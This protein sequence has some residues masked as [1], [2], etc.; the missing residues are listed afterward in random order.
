MIVALIAH[1]QMNDATKAKANELLRGHP[2]FKAHFERKMPRYLSGSDDQRKAKWYFAHAGTWPDLVRSASETVDREDVNR[3]NRPYWHYINMPI[4]LND[5]ERRKLETG[6]KL[7]VNRPP[8]ARA[9]A[10]R[11]GRA[12]GPAHG[13]R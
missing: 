13:Q 10:R 6:L 11:S 5:G 8:P 9:A 1:E 2:R 3:F 12:R 7:F 4:F